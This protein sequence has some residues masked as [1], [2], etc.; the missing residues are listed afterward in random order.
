MYENIEIPHSNFCIG[1]QAGTFCTIDTSGVS[2]FMRVKNSSGDLIRSYNVYPDTVLHSDSHSSTYPYHRIVDL[3]YIGPINQAS[4]YDDLTFFTLE[5]IYDGVSSTSCIIRKWLL[6]HSAGRLELYQSFTK[7]ASGS[8]TYNTYAFAV[9]NVKT[10][11][12]SSTEGGTGVIEMTTTSGLEKYDVLM[13]G[14]SN[15]T[16][17]LDAIEY[18]YVYSVSGDDVSIRTVN[19]GVPTQYEYLEDDPIT[20]FK[21]IYLFSNSYGGDEGSLYVLDSN[22]Y[23]NKKG[24]NAN[25]MYDTVYAAGW[26]NTLGGVSFCKVANILTL[27]TSDFE[28]FKSHTTKNM[29]SRSSYTP[30]VGLE[31]D[32]DSVYRLQR[33]ITVWD[34][35]GVLANVVWSTYNYVLDTILP[36]S[37]SVSLYVEP[38]GDLVR[39][40]TISLRAKVRDQMGVTLLG[41][42]IQFYKSGDAG[43]YFTPL[44]GQGITDSDGEVTISYT[45]GSFYQGEVKLSVRCDGSDTHLGSQYIWDVVYCQQHSTFEKEYEFNQILLGTSE[46]GLIK[47]TFLQQESAA[48]TDYTALYVFSQKSKFSFPG[49]HWTTGS[50]PGASVTTLE[51]G[52]L[53]RLHD[54]AIEIEIKQ[55]K[56][57]SGSVNYSQA[58]KH[59]NTFPIDQTY[60]SRHYSSGH[61]DDIDVYQFVFVQE[62]IPVFWSHKNSVDTRIWLR[63]RPFAASLNPT[64]FKIS[65]REKSYAGDTGWR[66]ITSEGVVTTFDAGGSMDGLEFLWFPSEH[67]HNNGIVFVLFDVFDTAFR[68]N[69]VVVDYWFVLIPDYKSPYIDNLIPDREDYDAAVGTNISFDLIDENT[70]IDMESFEMTVNYTRVYPDVTKVNDREYHIV[71]NPPVDFDYEKTVLVYVKVNDLGE[72]DNWLLDSW[73]FFCI[74]SNQP[75][76]NS[77]NYEPGLC[78]RGMDKKHGDISMQVY[79]AGDGIDKGSI[80][81]Y[82]GGPRRGVLISPIVYRSD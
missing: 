19:P 71:Y 56:D 11:F 24:K 44:N 29:K 60:I 40:Q 47:Q 49:G 4:F 70:G 39:V 53:P 72:N 69:R 8:D 2:A 63:L 3:K 79:G 15:D 7:T 17:N 26:N 57:V 27:S 1:P 54:G 51:Q 25:Q 16:T 41:K 23:Y 32:G 55:D 58:E 12:K 82:I 34:D 14:P 28:I 37:T 30:I 9:E 22:N 45:S 76:F 43:A 52:M 50:Q 31:F 64:T 6:N 66:D 61:K 80:L 75:W 78:A 42:N 65:I 5:K 74:E 68:P 13:L 20:V 81:V 62:A 21:D 67:F 36:Y 48:G 59:S 33:E 38:A 10:G 46:V 73:R 35:D 18:V 77:D